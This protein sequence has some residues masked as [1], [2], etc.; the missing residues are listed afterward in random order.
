DE[1]NYHT[2]TIHFTNSAATVVSANTYTDDLVVTINDE[3]TEPEEATV[4]V[5]YLSDGTANLVL[6][7]FQLT[8]D[9]TAM[10]V[11]N[12][13]LDGIEITDGD[14]YQTVTFD[15]TTQITKGDLSG[16]Y[17]WYGP[18]LGEVPIQLT[19]KMT[20][21][22]LYLSIDIDMTS[23]LSQVIH[24]E[25]GSDPDQ[26]DEEVVEV[27]STSTYTDDLVVTIN[28]DST[29][30]K[31]ATVTVNYLSDGTANLV[32][33][34]FQLTVDGSELPVGTIQLDG[35]EITDGDEYQTVTFDGTTQITKGDLSGVYFWYG[36]LLGDVSLQLDGKMTDEKLYLSIDIDMKS[37]IGDDV[38][39]TFGSD[40]DEEENNEPDAIASIPS[41]ADAANAVYDLSGRKVSAPSKGIY[42][43][44][45]KKVLVK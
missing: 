18:L 2:Y 28:T 42:I 12:I 4:T 15:G 13:E 21:E 40:F 14:E 34:N 22:S 16:V 44:N 23:L 24:V 36:P 38:L 11:G 27:V 26:S 6:K 7:N 8:V 45:G 20:D 41:E 35:I 17:F 10:P 43:I 1:T 32:L 37:L 25:F 39:V 9:S 5:E 29:E 3:S 31:E 30:P 19:G 33:K